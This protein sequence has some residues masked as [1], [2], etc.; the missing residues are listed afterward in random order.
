VSE[1]PSRRRIFVCRPGNG[2]DEVSCAKRILG[3]LARK[4]YRRP[5]TDKDTEQLLTFF[6]KGKN[7]GKTF[8]AGIEAG[9]QL[10]LASPEFLFRFEPDPPNVAVNTVYRVND[11][12]LAAP[13]LLPVEHHS[14]RPADEPGRAR[15]LEGSCGAGAT[16]QAHAG[17]SAS[18]RD[19]R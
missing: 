15:P 13:F 14:R 18:P 7:E 5:I 8:D 19:D 2:L 6:Q 4:S 17:R 1:T 3:N 12:E 9:I 11:L 10:I 16:G